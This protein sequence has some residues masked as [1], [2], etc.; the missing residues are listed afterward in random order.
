MTDENIF[1]KTF[2]APVETMDTKSPSHDCWLSH[3][4]LPSQG[5]PEALILS[6]S[7][8]PLTKQPP[9]PTPPSHAARTSQLLRFCH[10]SRNHPYHFVITLCRP[11]CPSAGSAEDR[12][13]HLLSL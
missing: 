7:R 13:Y 12:P 11:S 1:S 5:R 6:A 4:T 9:P 10:G 2:W 8:Q 3:A